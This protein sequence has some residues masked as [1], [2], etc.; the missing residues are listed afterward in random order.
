[1][2][3]KQSSTI[4]Y[5]GNK[6]KEI[7]YQGHYHDKMYKGSQLIW[8]K[9]NDEYEKDL[10]YR[11]QDYSIYNGI[12][13]FV[14]FLYKDVTGQDDVL[15][16][17][18]I[19]KFNAEKMCLDMLHKIEV[20]SVYNRY[21]IHACKDGLVLIKYDY[22][23]SKEN[24]EN[25]PDVGI[26]KYPIKQ[27]SVFKKVGQ[28]SFSEETTVFM[29][30]FVQNGAY[31]KHQFMV[32]GKDYY[33]KQIVVYDSNNYGYS[34]LVKYSY[35]GEIIKETPADNTALEIPNM[36]QQLDY[37]NVFSIGNRIFTIFSEKNYRSSNLRTIKAISY[38]SNLSDKK[39]YSM[40][41][42][43]T[44]A[45][46]D[47]RQ[48]STG[49]DMERTVKRY[50]AVCNGNLYAAG[51]INTGDYV[52]KVIKAIFQLSE[53]KLSTGIQ[54][55]KNV[56]ID[57]VD[58]IGAKLITHVS[59]GNTRCFYMIENGEIKNQYD[60]YN[61]ADGYAYDEDNIYLWIGV[62][63]YS[64]DKNLSY[65]KAEQERIRVIK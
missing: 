59:S 56:M 31:N 5:R 48:T 53:E 63:R 36:M 27:S 11:I 41:S 33:V 30:P 38:D 6:H 24:T 10:Y 42:G 51:K 40:D 18:Y 52:P 13:Y 55:Q 45:F 29:P 22:E 26:A 25:Q 20:V 17:I 32:F 37:M 1:M 44:Y 54:I 28:N 19:A 46:Q 15:Q 8:E 14:G 43:D 49:S 35:D 61:T 9:L 21:L 12:T 62:Y 34:S 39:K 16:G 65:I 58:A 60:S 23:F 7:Y 57:T 50:F 3:R 4:Y 64:F 47:L 2:A